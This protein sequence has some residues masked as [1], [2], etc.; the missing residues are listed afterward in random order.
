MWLFAH[1]F[2]SSFIQFISGFGGS[3]SACGVTPEWKSTIDY[4]PPPPPINQL[5]TDFSVLVELLRKW[6]EATKEVGQE[7]VLDTFDLDGVMKVM[8]IIK[9]SP[10]R[11]CKHVVTT[12]TPSFGY[13][14]HWNNHS[15]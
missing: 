12:R 10:E 14:L 7:Y 8:P 5:F 1:I 15:S 4:F 3:V 2:G 6:E 11:Y 13:E 9:K